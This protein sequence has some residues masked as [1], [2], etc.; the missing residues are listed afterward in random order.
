MW[1]VGDLDSEEGARLVRN[2]LK[3][4]QVSPAPG[5]EMASIE[6]I[7][8]ERCASRLGLVHVTTAASDASRGLSTALHR[9][10]VAGQ[11][12]KMSAPELEAL[13]ASGD[14]PEHDDVIAAQA[15]WRTGHRV[16]ARLEID[17]DQPHLLVNGRVRSA[18][19]SSQR[20]FD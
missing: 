9:L 19:S 1:V 11:L 13:V 12:D 16:A 6:K 20:V 5:Q 10:L 2:A 15:F 14:E 8:T 18:P 17:P 3:H 7:Q 4:I